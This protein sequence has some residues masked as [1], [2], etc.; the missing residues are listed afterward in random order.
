MT[1]TGVR[2]PVCNKK[3][4][5][6]DDIVVCPTCGAPHHR[7]CYAQK[8]ECAFVGEH[9]NGNIWRPIPEKGVSPSDEIRLCAV[10]GTRV[11]EDGLF[12]QVCGHNLHA[13]QAE[14]QPRNPNQR[15]PEEAQ[16]FG[17]WT[18]PGMEMMSDPLYATYGGVKPEETIDGVPVRDLAKYIGPS[19]AYYLPRFQHM[20]KSGK[21]ISV[22]FSALFFNFFYYF[23]R[24][25]YLLGFVMLAVYA[26]S[27]VPSFIS[28]W[29]SMPYTLQYLEEMGVH[30]QFEQAGIHFP[31]VDQVDVAKVEHYLNLGTVTQF[32]SFLINLCLSLCSNRI[33]LEKCVKDTRRLSESYAPPNAEDT[34]AM[35]R[36]GAILTAKGGINKVSILFAVIGVIALHFI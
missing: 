5:Q 7:E 35:E 26:L 8:N 24:K 22:N 10:C 2:C 9:I 32:I 1:Y 34:A 13:A 3:F 20:D 33:Y 17:G 4:T 29:E 6:S 36:Y 15:P 14:A 31:S 11:P 19:S 16:Q 28:S 21:T 25:M 27:L 30:F 12:C 23:Y 18:L